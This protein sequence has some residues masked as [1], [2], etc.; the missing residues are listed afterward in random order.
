MC[1]ICYFQFNGLSF[2]ISRRHRRQRPTNQRGTLL[3][4]KFAV[5]PLIPF[6]AATQSKHICRICTN[7]QEWVVVDVGMDGWMAPLPLKLLLP[8]SS[9]TRHPASSPFPPWLLL[10]GMV[11]GDRAL[12]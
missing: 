9:L 3:N 2:T 6:T 10:R 11:V 8:C 7:E 5:V 4:G 1:V 12:I